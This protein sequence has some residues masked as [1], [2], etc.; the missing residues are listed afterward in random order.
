MEN[1]IKLTGPK[2]VFN[3]I[4]T[5]FV[6]VGITFALA[7]V[8]G[9]VISIYVD[10]KTIDIGI[11]YFIYDGWNNISELAKSADPA[12]V[13]YSY[14]SFIL[15]FLVYAGSIAITYIFGIKGIVK[16][17]R[18][19]IAHEPTDIYRNL[20]IVSLTIYATSILLRVFAWY[21]Y[22]AYIFVDVSSLSVSLGWGSS[23]VGVFM[24][25]TMILSVLYIC[26][27]R[28]ETKNIPESIRNIVI[29]IMCLILMSVIEELA[30]NPFTISGYWTREWTL[31]DTFVAFAGLEMTAKGTTLLSVTF[32]FTFLALA[33]GVALLVLAVRYLVFKKR[34]NNTLIATF[35]GILSGALIVAM[36]I[37]KPALQEFADFYLTDGHGISNLSENFS[38]ALVCLTLS[39]VCIC[40]VK[41]NKKDDDNP[42]IEE[43]SNFEN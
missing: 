42:Q 27:E 34:F 6:L 2:R 21:G 28:F 26:L 41:P 10:Y 12:T 23:T 35:A 8:W 20:T 4:L 22:G 14:F 5:I 37:A 19:L 15:S 24:W 31:F 9:D 39:I 16:G 3:V 13:F 18:C 1:N 30:V 17:I 36:V 7:F 40:L 43:Q 29:S 38:L 32:A 11:N 25:F 33:A